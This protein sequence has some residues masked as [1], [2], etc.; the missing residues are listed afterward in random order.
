MLPRYVS[1]SLFSGDLMRQAADGRAR[2]SA[3]GEAFP[4]LQKALPTSVEGFLP[5]GC[6]DPRGCARHDHD[7]EP[8]ISSHIR[9]YRVPR[10]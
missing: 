8:H 2:V 6:M 5:T 1:E 3:I 9:T 7:P 4:A 10:W